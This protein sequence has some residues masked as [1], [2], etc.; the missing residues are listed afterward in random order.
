MCNE[1][2]IGIQV[3][4]MNPY[5]GRLFVSNHAENKY[6]VKK[7]YAESNV[8]QL[9]LP[10]GACDMKITRFVSYLFGKVQRGS[11]IFQYSNRCIRLK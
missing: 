5:T 11:N 2:S 3:E 1:R 8:G 4:T 9:D 10:I 6:C 7:F